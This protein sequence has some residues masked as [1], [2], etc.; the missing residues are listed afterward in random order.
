MDVRG[1][2][3]DRLFAG[4]RRVAGPGGR[5]ILVPKPEHLIAMTVQALTD[6]PERMWQDLADI[7]LLLRVDGDD[8]NEA[9]GYFVRAG[10]E[11]KWREI[12]AP[13]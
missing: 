10:L 8:L 9:R 6:A 2:T 7:G 3:R 1:D 11:E 5:A 13:R 12:T 4:A